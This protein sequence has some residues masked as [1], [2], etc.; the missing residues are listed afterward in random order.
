MTLNDPLSNALSNI[1][2]CEKVGKEKCIV[3][4]VSKTIKRV[5]TIMKE[6][7]YVGDLES[8]NTDHGEYIKLN[9]IGKINKCGVIK[10]RFPAKVKDFEKYEK[11]YLPAKNFGIIIMSTPKG[12]MT[13]TQAA[14]EG[15]GGRLLAY[16]Y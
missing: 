16:C 2:N 9:L 4:N 6:N 5:L 7:G 11:R 15:M 8:I 1:F 14:K 3:R 10:P 13:H 12:I